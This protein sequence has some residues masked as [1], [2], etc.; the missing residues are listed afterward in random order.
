MKM[1]QNEIKNINEM[2]KVFLEKVTINVCV[3]NDKQGMIKAEKLLEKLS[4][5]KPVKNSAKKRL[6]TWQIR[7]GLPIGYKVTLRGDDAKNFLIWALKSKSNELKES[8]LDMYGNFSLGFSEYLELSSMKY[9]ADIGIMGFELMVTFARK[10]F[11]IKSR[12]LK[13]ERIPKRHKLSK[14]EVKEV[15]IN[16]YGVK[17]K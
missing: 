9:D 6:A 10:G 12:K 5:K 3:G 7:P 15:L 8:S 16:D 1:A 4:S 14:E 17:F 11:R 13:T 2:K